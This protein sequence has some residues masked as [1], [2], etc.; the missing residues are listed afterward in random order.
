MH[1]VIIFHIEDYIL[2]LVSQDLNYV[3]IFLRLT[4]LNLSLLICVCFLRA[5]SSLVQGN[6]G[7]KV[8]SGYYHL[9]LD[10]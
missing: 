3:Y 7:N 9:F 6:P 2:K 10:P 4:L 8:G 5:S 1:T